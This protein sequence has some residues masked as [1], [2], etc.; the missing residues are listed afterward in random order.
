MEISPR[1]FGAFWPRGAAKSTNA[2]LIAVMAG[3]RGLRNYAFYVCATQDQAD[4]HVQS[5]A[6]LL[7]HPTLAQTYPRIAR[8]AVT[9]YGV[10]KGWRRNRLV[11]D[12]GFTIDAI[13]LD[14]AAR[15]IRMEEDRPGLM[16]IDDIDADEDTPAGVEKKIRFLTRKILAAGAYNNAVLFVQNIIHQRSI[17]ARLS[18]VSEERA[19]FLQGMRV[20]GPYPALGTINNPDAVYEQDENGDWQIIRGTP[21]WNGQNLERCQSLLNAIGIVAFRIECQHETD[22]VENGM[23]KDVEFQYVTWLP[24]LV[25][26]VVW[27]DPA[28][29]DT[30]R[31]DSYGIQCDGIGMDNLVYRL[32]S[33]EDTSSPL[34]AMKR[35]IL[36]AIK[37]KATKVGIETDQGGDTWQ[38]VFSTAVE[39]LRAA[40]VQVHE[41]TFEE[42]KAGSGYGN[43]AYRAQ[44]ML[45]AYMM[46]VFRH[47]VGG[48]IPLERALKRFP[49]RKPF[50][51]VDASYWSWL[52]LVNGGDGGVAVGGTLSPLAQFAS[53]R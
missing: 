26:T 39:Q 50:D 12:A 14:T 19:R 49:I 15:G 45:G 18:G 4:D 9:K 13:G 34:D 27:V 6:A 38:V 33:W 42:I 40:K 29:T 5:I 36:M 8:P 2:E 20:S 10:Y 53:G 47:L 3:A 11:T 7:D 28:V 16:I 48:T 1:P 46:N 22:I 23:F 32:E 17:A 35:A 43:K 51:L 37:W 52:D 21:T 24:D 25:R 30:D 44:Q 31:S 41:I